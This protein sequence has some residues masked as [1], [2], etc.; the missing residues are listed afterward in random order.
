MNDLSIEPTWATRELPILAAALRR[1]DA[2]D[3]DVH[4]LE[5]IRQELGFT[6]DELLA[7]LR[8]LR[9][10][11]PPYVDVQLM[12]GWTREHAGGGFVEEVSERARREL[13]QWPSPENLVDQLAAALAR[14]AEEEPAA[15]RKG[16]LAQAAEVVSGMARDIAVQVV[17]A[18]LGRI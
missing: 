15:E 8:A 7:G 10:A 2:G 12:G 4:Q 1:V 5:G 18:R 11:D 16:R 17:A 6:P 13:G 14:A 3:F 9:S